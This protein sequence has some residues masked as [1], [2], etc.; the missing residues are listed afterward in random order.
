MRFELVSC[1]TGLS[2]RRAHICQEYHELYL[3]RKNCHV[4]KFY[5]SMY[6]NCGEIE[7]RYQRSGAQIVIVSLCLISTTARLCQNGPDACLKAVEFID[8]I[9]E[10]VEQKIASICQ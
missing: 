4:E 7:K 10:N 5:L 8:K 6:D 2:S 3:W 1:P 9:N